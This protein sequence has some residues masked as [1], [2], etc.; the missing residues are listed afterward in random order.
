[1]IKTRKTYIKANYLFIIVIGIPI[2]F[3]SCKKQLTEQ[4]LIDYIKSPDNGVLI[5]KKVGSLNYKVYYRP[6]D[7]LVNQEL[8]AHNIATDSLINHYKNIYDK[9]LYF[10]VSISQNNQEVLNNLAGNKQHFGSMVNQLAFGMDQKVTLLTSQK[11]TLQLKDYIYPRTYGVGNST[12]IMFVF[13]NKD[14]NQAEWIQ[15]VIEDFGLQTGDARF[16]FLTKDI[17]KT[18]SLKFE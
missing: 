8:K 16:K 5:E 10:I 13:E 4:E 2:L 9:N 15:M 7:M 11:D 1:M 3:G 12:D 14:I 6:S 18:P 17:R